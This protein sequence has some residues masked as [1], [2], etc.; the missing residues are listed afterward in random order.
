MESQISPSPPPSPSL[1][2]PPPHASNP[3]NM[4][5]KNRPQRFAFLRAL[6]TEPKYQALVNALDNCV[7]C[8][9]PIPH[10]DRFPQ[11]SGPA[12]STAEDPGGCRSHHARYRPALRDIGRA[13]E[14]EAD[15][16]PPPGLPSWVHTSELDIMLV[17]G[18][19]QREPLADVG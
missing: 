5:W 7:V 3:A 17:D 2:P 13:Q 6:S 9:C 15:A 12:S 1:P 8:A 18:L 10:S 4:P 14:V 11:S 19:L 16:T